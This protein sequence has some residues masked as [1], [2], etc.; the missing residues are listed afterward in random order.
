MM[1]VFLLLIAL[2][3]G[4]CIALQVGSNAQLKEAT[5]EPLLAILLNSLI[6]IVLLTGALIV[7]RPLVAAS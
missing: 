3:A 6:G 7:T 4:A 2:L 1:M 5:G